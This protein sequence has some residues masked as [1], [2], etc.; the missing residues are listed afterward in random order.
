M[1][2]NK[3]AVKDNR[4][5]KY[6][7]L[8]IVFTVVFIALILVINLVFS[9]LSLSGSITVDLTQEDFTSI[10]EESERL[11]TELGKDLDITITFM[12][13]RDKF[14]MEENTYNGINLTGIVRDLAENYQKT[15]D[16]SGEK[17]TVKVQYKELDTDPE[18][19]KK[20]LEESTTKLSPTS[21]IVQGKHHYRVLDLSSFFTVNEEGAYHAFNG[22]YRFTTAMLQSSISEKQLVTLTYG[23]GEPIGADGVI[24]LSSAVAGLA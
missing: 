17:G 3:T 12:S 22:E 24:S 18:F 21:V 19:E 13:A 6:G 1:N 7:S 8:S 14:D 10:G 16:G 9:G 5:Y 20:F 15:F 2:N 23:N 11:L 4:R